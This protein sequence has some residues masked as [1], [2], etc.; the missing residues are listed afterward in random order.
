MFTCTDTSARKNAGK[1]ISNAMS[2]I[3]RLYADVEEEYR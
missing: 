3:I 2:R 1:L